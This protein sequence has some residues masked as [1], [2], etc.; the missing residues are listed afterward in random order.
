MLYKIIYTTD[1]F[2]HP[3]H[4]FMPHIL[5]YNVPNT[6]SVMPLI[7]Q[8]NVPNTHPVMPQILHH[9]VPNTHPV[10]PHILHH[11]VTNTNSVMPYLLHH[12]VP[13]THSVMP[14]LLLQLSPILIC[15]YSPTVHPPLP[16]CS[17]VL[18]EIPS[19]EGWGGM[20]GCRRIKRGSVI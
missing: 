3:P 20:E 10:L 18:G 15:Y 9:N 11:T 16:D 7:L 2:S 4:L 12:N 19:V 17:P 14:H 1:S 5:H 13:N 8:H 6:N